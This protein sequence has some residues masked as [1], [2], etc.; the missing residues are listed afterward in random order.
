METPEP[1]CPGAVAP[2]RTR[3]FETPGA[4][5]RAY[6]WG[7]EKAPA[8][9]CAH[10]FLDH[11]RGFDAVAPILAQHYRVVSVDSRGHGES[12]RC[13]SYP[14]MMDVRDTLYVLRELGAGTHLLGHSKGGGQLTDAATLAGDT[15]G[16]IVNLDG[17]GPPDDGIF[18]RPGLP[19]FNTMTMPERCAH[20]LDGRRRAAEK[21]EWK[22]RPSLDDLVERRGRQNPM[23]DKTWLRYFVYHASYE[24]ED[25][26]RW[27]SDAMLTSPGFGPFRPDWIAPAWVNLQAP[28][29]AVIGGVDDHW[30]PLP[31]E[32]L[33]PRLAHVPRLERATIEGSGHFIH[34]EKPAEVSA[35]IL[36]FLGRP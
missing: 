13:G 23:L 31:E 35:L 1:K 30:G 6:E 27:K 18:Q 19:D 7:D 2:D 17:F 10:G 4:R 12:S 21:N 5:L 34:M 26:W 33:G 20:F 29:L 14:W 15:I 9:L 8:I 3:T 24:A 32:T 28:M 16:K 25:G 36:D 22:A 11:G